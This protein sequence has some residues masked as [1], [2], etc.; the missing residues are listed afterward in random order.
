MTH[1]PVAHNGRHGKQ[2]DSTLCTLG[3]AIAKRKLSPHVWK[4]MV[5]LGVRPRRF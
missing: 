4:A 5:P 2:K 3:E 1:V